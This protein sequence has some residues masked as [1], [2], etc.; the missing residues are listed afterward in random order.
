MDCGSRVMFVLV[1]V[2]LCSISMDDSCSIGMGFSVG[3]LFRV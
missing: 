3:L 1:S 2:V